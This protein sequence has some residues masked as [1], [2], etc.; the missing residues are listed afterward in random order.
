[1]VRLAAADFTGD[2]KQDLVGVE[3]GSGK[4]W[5]YPGNGAGGLGDRVQIGAGWGAMS[6]LTAADFTGDGKPDLAAVE[7][8]T[9]NLYVYPG[10]GSASGMGTLGDRTQIGSGWGGM[11]ELTAL[12]VN[13][14][15][16][17]DLLSIDAGG[18]LWA[19]PGSGALNGTST[20]GNRT[21]IGA[22]WGAMTELTVPGDLDSDGKADLVAIDG[23]GT[24]WK[25]PSTGSLNGMNTLGNRGQLGTNWDSMRQLVGADFNGDGKGDLDAVQAPAEATGSLYFYPGNGT[26][27]LG[28]RA[29]IGTNW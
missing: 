4:L 16:T 28:N 3:A 11:R 17:A 10:A 25:Y 12:D 20:L 7:N 15:G 19:Y 26:G 22:G 18:G 27:G 2:G 23:A 5:L 13:K 29:Q 14:D 9:G 8:A 24:L 6:E 1:M 21:Q